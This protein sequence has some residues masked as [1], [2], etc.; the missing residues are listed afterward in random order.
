M[1]HA[2]AIRRVLASAAI[3][4][5]S[6]AARPRARRQRQAGPYCAYC[7][8]SRQ[9]STL[10]SH[11]A[12]DAKASVKTKEVCGV[13][14]CVYILYLYIMAMARWRG[15]HKQRRKTP[16]R[17]KKSVRIN[18]E[19]CFD[20]D[21]IARWAGG[22]RTEKRNRKNREE[23]ENA[24][25]TRSATV[26]IWTVRRPPTGRSNDKRQQHKIQ[27]RRPSTVDIKIALTLTAWG[28][29]AGSGAKLPRKPRKKPSHSSHAQSVRSLAGCSRIISRATKKRRSSWMKP[30]R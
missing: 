3:V 1:Q 27:H 12:R 19:I 30:W 20:I 13:F 22:A 14:V 25:S 4:L 15:R 18:A 11:L 2:S 10:I 24:R 7:N 8:T 9:T 5:R 17:E 28:S 29:A 26:P 6:S 16:R 21:G 23:I